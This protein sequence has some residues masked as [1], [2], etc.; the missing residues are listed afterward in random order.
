MN[1]LYAFVWFFA[2]WKWGDWRN[3][4]NYYPTLLFFI[5]G[6]FLYL[7][8]LSDHYPMWRYNP[9]G[10]DEQVH[11]TNTHV[12]FSIMAVKYP[13]TILIFLYRFPK[14][15]SLFKK[16][17]YIAGWVL[18]YTVNEIIDI[19]LNLIKYSNGWSLKW[20]IFFNTTMFTILIVHHKRPVAAWILSILFIIFLWN[21]FNVPSSVFR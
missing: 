20:S 17:L 14:N 19:K 13:A 8:L 7:Y 6:D 12:T 1:A 10:F 9:Q 16:I 5:L 3:W 11:L 18:L 15:R 21:Q 4:R 2:L